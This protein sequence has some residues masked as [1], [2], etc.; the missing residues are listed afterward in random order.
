MEALLLAVGRLAGG[1]GVLVTLAAA[2]ARAL[3]NYWVAG[4]QTGTILLG[5]MALMLIGCLG[6]LAAIVSARAGRRD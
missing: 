1:L 5:G 3:G 4:Y 2:F 6:F